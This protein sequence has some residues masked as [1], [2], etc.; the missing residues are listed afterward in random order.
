MHHSTLSLINRVV[1]VAAIG[2][3][4]FC[5][6]FRL[7]NGVI[8]A[9]ASAGKCANAVYH[10][11]GGQ[12]LGCQPDGLCYSLSAVSVAGVIVPNRPSV[13]SLGPA[14]K[15]NVSALD[16]GT[17]AQS[18]GPQLFYSQRFSTDAAQPTAKIPG[19]VISIDRAVA[20]IAD[21][22]IRI[23]A[24][25]GKRSPRNA[26]GRVQRAMRGKTQEQMA[27]GVKGIDKAVALTGDIG[28]LYR[29]LLG[30]G[31]KQ[32]AIDILDAEWGKVAWDLRIR[33][34]SVGRLGC[35]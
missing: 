26:P 25:E 29:V 19:R 32:L 1:D 13:S 17:A 10:P 31:H 16:F 8:C 12:D 11:K 7:I 30:V 18:Q 5:R 20:E 3:R 2:R 27:V 24:A 35:E 15:N 23:E 21:Q 14:V 33:K 34:A 9:P 6:P 28:I 22:D 4:P